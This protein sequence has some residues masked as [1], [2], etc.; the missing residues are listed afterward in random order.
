MPRK[1]RYAPAGIIFHVINRANARQRIFHDE[2]DYASFAWLLREARLKFEVRVL[3]WCVMP[4]HVHLVLQPQSA[5]G[6]SRM[7][8]WVMTSHVQRHRKRH[9]TIGR[10]WQGRFK[11]FPIQESAHFVTVLR[12]VE[13]NPLRAGLVHSSAEWKWSSLQERLWLEGPKGVVD[14]P[15]V[16]LPEPWASWVDRELDSEELSRLRESVRRGR[17]FG[18]TEW[19]R[20]TAE[21]LDLLSTLRPLGR[22]R[23][24]ARPGPTRGIGAEPPES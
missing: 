16:D 4:N 8:H 23:T 2:R 7:M 12:Y 22:P 9:E 18:S 6:L 21:R 15:P 17:P 24:A 14:T 5:G 19:M 10:V 3:A 13:R 20:G 1:N 11:A